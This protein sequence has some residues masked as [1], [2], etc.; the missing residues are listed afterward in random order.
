MNTPNANGERLQVLLAEY[1]RI[2]DE[3]LH[4][5]TTQQTVVN[6]IIVLIAAEVAFFAQSSVNTQ[7][8]QY[9]ALLLLLPLPFAFLGLYHSAYTIRIHKLADF[10]DGELREKIEAVVGPGALRSRSYVPTR[11]IFLLAKA[12]RDGR[13]TYLSL[14][15]LKCLPQLVPLAIVLSLRGPWPWWQYVWFAVD[16]LICAWSTTGQN[17]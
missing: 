1:E 15:G 10:M 7:L 3:I 11:H 14:F 4:H 16:L 13:L 17:D 8:V 6:F 2:R 12:A 9:P 5:K